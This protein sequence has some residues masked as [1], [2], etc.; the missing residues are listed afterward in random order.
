MTGR[1]AIL[2][3]GFDE[4]PAYYQ[5]SPLSE[6]PLD[7]MYAAAAVQ[8]AEARIARFDEPGRA[9]LAAADVLVVSTT[10]SYLQWNNHPLGLGLF[11][12]VLGRAKEIIG[13]DVPIVAFGPHVPAHYQELW[14]RSRS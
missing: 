1:I 6:E 2:S 13:A 11:T 7:V 10:N 9:V 14:L 5:G 12:G 3:T 4:V 8:Q